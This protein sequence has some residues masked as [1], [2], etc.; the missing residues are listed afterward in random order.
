MLKLLDVSKA[1]AFHLLVQLRKVQHCDRL[2]V[3]LATYE[4]IEQAT[5]H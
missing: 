2:E 5:H 1:D 4:N 3:A